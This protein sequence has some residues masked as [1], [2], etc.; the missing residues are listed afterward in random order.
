MNKHPLLHKFVMS[1]YNGRDSFGRLVAIDHNDIACI[2]IAKT[3]QLHFIDISNVKK[4]TH[5][6]EMWS[7]LKGTVAR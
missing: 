3:N 6:D 2:K 7:N 4:A 1:S 5:A